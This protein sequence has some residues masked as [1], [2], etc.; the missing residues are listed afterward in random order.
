MRE[1]SNEEVMAVSGAGIY[2]SNNGLQLRD[3]AVGAVA[4]A[5]MG[6][7]IGA[8]VGLVAGSITGFR[9]QTQAN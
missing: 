5:I 2:S 4:G 1:I 3:M 7:P 9:P 6:G 8:A